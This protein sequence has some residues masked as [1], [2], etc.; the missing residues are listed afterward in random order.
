MIEWS[1][2]HLFNHI[3]CSLIRWA[4]LVTQK[5]IKK[6][7]CHN[8]KEVYYLPSSPLKISRLVQRVGT[9]SA[10]DV[11]HYRPASVSSNNFH[12]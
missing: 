6:T 4:D 10:S 12:D 3:K 7:E 11:H 5:Q 9:E 8:G 2:G 1:W